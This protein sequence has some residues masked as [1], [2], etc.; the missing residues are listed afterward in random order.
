MG[1][2]KGKMDK[3]V[4]ELGK[5]RRGGEAVD[6]QGKQGTESGWFVFIGFY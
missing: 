5:K 6:F 1:L 4:V 3:G 2:E